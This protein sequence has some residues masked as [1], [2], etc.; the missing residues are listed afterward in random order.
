MH[1]NPHLLLI[2]ALLGLG[3]GL[4]FHFVL[5]RNAKPRIRA[6]GYS[7]G[8]QA[9]QPLIDEL[10]YSINKQALEI[11]SLKG[12]RLNLMHDHHQALEAISQ[13]A[14]E[15]VQA[16]TQR[17]LSDHELL[18]V[19]RAIVQLEK[20]SATYKVIGN[21]QRT[22]DTNATREQL[23]GLVTRMAAAPSGAQRSVIV[24]GPEGCGKTRDASRIAEALGLSKIK[25]DWHRDA[26]IEAADTLYL[27]NYAGPYI[28]WRN[29][30][31]YDEAMQRVAQLEAAA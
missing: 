9:R 6:Q 13:A 29:V 16:H 31:T 25:D 30:M 24:Y 20:S 11:T 17:C 26:P 5:L 2:G 12:Q 1:S 21:D 8:S 7:A 4:A 22:R 15:R 10:Q 18:W 3:I 14:D 28:T 27:T 19:K 23:Q